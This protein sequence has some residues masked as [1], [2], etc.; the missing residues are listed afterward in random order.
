MIS[1]HKITKRKK[2][3]YLRN[4]EQLTSKTPKNMSTLPEIRAKLTNNIDGV[5]RGVRP[6]VNLEAPFYAINWLSTRAK[7]MYYFYLLLASGTVKK[8][9]GIAF[10]K[11]DVTE[12]I[13]GD[14][15]GRRDSLLIVY[16]PR[17]QSFKT[18]MESTYFKIVS[19]FRILAVTKFTFGFSHK[20]AIDST[21]KK[22]DKL[23]YA[24][25]YFKS[26]KDGKAIFQELAQILRDDITIKYGGQI[27]ATLNSQAKNKPIEQVPNLM[28]GLYVFQSA[29]ETSLRNLFASE[30]YQAFLEGLQ[31]SYICLLKRTLV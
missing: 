28:D 9:G 22:E 27:V 10:F 20:I 14:V 3:L 25:H 5:I 15:A 6:D 1:T 2:S 24:L 30:A 8:T 16:Y 31:T 7:L 17:G 18:L 13:L 23:N 19:I 26:E 21:S 12:T 4:A 29:K 11:A